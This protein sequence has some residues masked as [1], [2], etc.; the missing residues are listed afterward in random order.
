[1]SVDKRAV[2]VS[3]Y[4]YKSPG[5]EVLPHAWFTQRVTNGSK[6]PNPKAEVEV[7]R[8]MPLIPLWSR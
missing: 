2:V 6:L 8:A 5:G 3:E 1:M 7:E 4:A